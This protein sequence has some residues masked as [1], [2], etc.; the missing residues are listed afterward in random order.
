MQSKDSLS[1]FYAKNTKKSDI[2]LIYRDGNSQAVNSQWLLT[3][4]ENRGC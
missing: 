3:T 2:S 4:N 1:S